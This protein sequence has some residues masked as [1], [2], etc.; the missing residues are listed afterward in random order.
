MNPR[1]NSVLSTALVFVPLAAALAC[2]SRD[3]TSKTS[4][5]VEPAADAGTADAGTAD[6]GAQVPAG[7]TFPATALSTFSTTAKDLT[8]ALRTSPQQPPL[9]GPG[10]SAQFTITDANGAPV[11]GLQISI[12]TYMPVMG[13]ACTPVSI[14]VTGEGN[15]LYVA[16]PI[17][18]SMP[19]ACELI[20][21]LSRPVADGGKLTDKA[22]SPRFTVAQ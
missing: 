16:S 6:A 19:G 12:A 18:P 2:G 13:H 3:G 11:D 4:S 14:K 9:V 7:P 17:D 20:L 21:T 1:I 5:A 10:S 15:G 22:T 8:I